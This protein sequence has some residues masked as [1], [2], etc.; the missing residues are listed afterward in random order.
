MPRKPPDE[1][2][3]PAPSTLA[4]TRPLTDRVQDRVPRAVEHFQGELSSLEQRVLLHA[5][6]KRSFAEIGRLLR[7]SEE[8]V[9]ALALT[10]SG[11]G[12]LVLTA[13]PPPRP[14]PRPRSGTRPKAVLPP[15]PRREEP[16]EAP[17]I[18]IEVDLGD[19]F[20]VRPNSRR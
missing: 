16:G 9:V 17:E 12:A 18:V 8:E 10:L 11:R 20:E 13:R 1:A 5:D 14:P 4:V 15:D 19:F 6:G 3:A 2:S 7:L